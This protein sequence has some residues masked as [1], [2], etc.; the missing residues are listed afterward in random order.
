MAMALSDDVRAIDRSC[1]SPINQMTGLSAKPHG[2][3]HI[4]MLVA[5]LDFTCLGS[6]FGNESNNRVRGIDIH[7][8]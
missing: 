4:R 1:L 8:G 5:L 2:A 6:P 7:L 3:A